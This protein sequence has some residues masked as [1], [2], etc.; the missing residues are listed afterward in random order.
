MKYELTEIDSG[1]VFRL[2]FFTL[3]IIL[4]FIGLIVIVITLITGRL[5]L[6]I[7]FFIVGAPLIAFLKA[8][9]FWI[10]SKIYNIFAKKFGGI[11]INIDESS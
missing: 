1:S 4:G 10:I 8:S 11:N 3:L 7:I 9:L 6:G 2:V 5:V